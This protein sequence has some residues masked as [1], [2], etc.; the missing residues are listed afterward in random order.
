MVN[1]PP[2]L[3]RKLSRQFR[4]LELETSALRAPKINAALVCSA[5]GSVNAKLASKLANEAAL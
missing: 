1:N 4:G 5:A 3:T 2:Q